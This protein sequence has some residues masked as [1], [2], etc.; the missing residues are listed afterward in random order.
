MRNRATQPQLWLSRTPFKDVE[1]NTDGL[2][3]NES[4]F[5]NVKSCDTSAHNF[6]RFS[7]S[8]GKIKKIPSME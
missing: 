3:K 8:K 5:V 4:L 6:I 7:E 2:E 1:E